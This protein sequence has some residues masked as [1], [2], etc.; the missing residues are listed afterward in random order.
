M[1]S[2]KTSCKPKLII[3]GIDTKVIKLLIAV[4]E[5]ERAVSPFAKCVIKFDV[6]PPGQ[7]EIMMTPIAISGDKWKIRMRMKPTMGR[8]I[9]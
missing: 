3:K 6:G 9:N 1:P 7:A 4:S 8:M 2:P 5:T